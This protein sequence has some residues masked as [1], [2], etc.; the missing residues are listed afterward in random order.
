VSLPS[1]D[2]LMYVEAFIRDMRE[3]GAAKVRVGDVVVDF[4]LPLI[5]QVQPD[6]GETDPKAEAERL[7]Y[8]SSD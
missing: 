5:A 3:L 8:G 2:A 6:S 7:M 4:D 1:K